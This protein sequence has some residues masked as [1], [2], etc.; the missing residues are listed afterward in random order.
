MSLNSVTCKHRIVVWERAK[1]LD[2]TAP[3]LLL[4][5]HTKFL[6]CVVLY[7]ESELRDVELLKECFVAIFAYSKE[8]VVWANRGS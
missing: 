5:D 8:N 4:S 3:Y 6:L 7:S 2:M 1:Y